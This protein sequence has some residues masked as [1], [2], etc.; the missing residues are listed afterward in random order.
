MLTIMPW[1]SH[2]MTTITSRPACRAITGSI[3]TI[4]SCGISVTDGTTPGM[5]PGMVGTVPITDMVGTAGAIGDGVMAIAT[6][7]GTMVG[8]PDGTMVGRLQHHPVHIVLAEVRWLMA[9]VVPVVTEAQLLLH[10]EVE[11]MPQLLVAALRQVVETR[12]RLLPQEA[13]DSSRA[14][15]IQHLRAAAAAHTALLRAAHH[16]PAAS[17]LP[18]AAA[19]EDS[20]AAVAEA[21]AAEADVNPDMR[22]AWGGEVSPSDR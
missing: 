14:A 10:V 1:T 19:V 15:D 5:I 7:D 11:I 21:V 3:I 2:T 17:R 9:D 20:P 8:D 13:A 18:L 4:P 16:L 12:Q 6:W 22:A